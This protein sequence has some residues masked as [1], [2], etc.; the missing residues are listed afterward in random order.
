ML[1]AQGLEI[2][3]ARALAARL[4]LKPT[5]FVES[6]FDRLLTPGAKP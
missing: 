6:R 3:L 5:F 4:G 2:D 1:H